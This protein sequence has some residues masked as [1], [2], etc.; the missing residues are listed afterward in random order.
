MK[1]LQEWFA[2]YGESH[3]NST[4]KKI[5]FGAV[6]A[7]FFSIIWLLQS[8]PAGFIH[9][10]LPESLSAFKP[11]INYSSIL[12]IIGVLFYL[13]LSIVIA[14]SMII[15]V[16]VALWSG[17]YIDQHLAPLWIVG[18]GVF[19]ISWIVQFYGHKVE[20]KKPSFFKDLQFLLIGP[21]WVM[22]FLYQKIG[23]KY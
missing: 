17:H 21:A 13:R 4:N 6:P 9:S 3:Q 5:H 23:I 20:G 10:F 22:S 14:I 1:T 18:L 12:V 8:I 16:S 15:M 11:Y 7:I 2:E 19:V